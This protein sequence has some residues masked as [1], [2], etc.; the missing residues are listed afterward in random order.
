[1]EKPYV[2]RFKGCGDAKAERKYSAHH[3]VAHYLKKHFDIAEGQRQLRLQKAAL[4]RAE[5]EPKPE[6]EPEP[7]PE[8]DHAADELLPESPEQLT[9]QEILGQVGDVVI[10]TDTGQ[11]LEERIQSLKSQA[12]I[13]QKQ[14]AEIGG[15]LEIVATELTRTMAAKAAWD[16][17]ESPKVKTAGG[18]PSK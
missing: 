4:A 16:K 14:L 10:V 3:L 6:P 17:A 2:C 9:V 11:Y 12:E 13:I 1:M 8:P 7:I 18:E 15:Q 5:G